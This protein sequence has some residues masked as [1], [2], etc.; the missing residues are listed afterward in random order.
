MKTSGSGSAAYEAG[1]AWHVDVY[2]AARGRLFRTARLLT[3][4]DAVAEEV[5][6][7]AFLRVHMSRRQ[8]DNAAAYLRATVVNLCRNHSRR[9]RLEHSLY[10]PP[11]A[12][13]SCPEVDETFAIV[14]R[15]P[16]RQRAVLVLRFYEDLT[17]V[18]IA[19]VLGCPLGSVKSSLH[20]GL[21]KLRKEVSR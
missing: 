16:Y 12:V 19:E 17:E 7:E 1:D 10:D 4:S 8:P 21:A 3:G 15:L 11:A 5:V 9:M 14:A 18:E 2:E 13:V 20:R 6:Q